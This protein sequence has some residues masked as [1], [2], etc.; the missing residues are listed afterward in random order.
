[1]RYSKAVNYIFIA[2]IPSRDKGEP[3]MSYVAH[4]NGDGTYSV[5]SNGNAITGGKVKRISSPT[6]T[7]HTLEGQV[8]HIAGPCVATISVPGVGEIEDVPV[9]FPACT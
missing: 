4:S 1:M 5:Q 8:H 2:P 6:V 7:S 9:I 3:A